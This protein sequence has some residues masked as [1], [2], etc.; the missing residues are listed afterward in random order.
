M[1]ENGKEVIQQLINFI[2]SWQ[3][4]APTRRQV[5]SSL[6]Q[7]DSLKEED[8]IVEALHINKSFQGYVAEAQPL[9]AAS[10]A[11]KL[12]PKKPK[13]RKLTTADA[14]EQER[15]LEKSKKA[16]ENKDG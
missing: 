2:P 16:F 10:S 15:L 12:P 9:V 13:K 1:F 4:L 6:T 11:R 14:E 8:K 5:A 3:E 7:W